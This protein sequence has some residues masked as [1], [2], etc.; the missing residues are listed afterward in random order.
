MRRRAWLS[1]TQFL[2]ANSA[3]NLIPGPNSTEVAMHVGR[4]RSGPGGLVAAGVCFI[5]PA[6]VMV[7]ALAWA[8]VEYGAL[9]QVQ[10]VAYGAKPAALA[11]IALAVVQFARTAWSSVATA[12]AG[13]AAFGLALAGVPELFTIFGMGLAGLTLRSALV[14]AVPLVELTLVFLKLGCVVFGSGYVLLA[15][16]R[17]DIVGRGWV[18]EA[19]LVDAVA[20]GQLTPGPLFT[21]ATFL[22]YLIA[23]FPGAALATV[24]IF[25]PAFV[26]VAITGRWIERMRASARAG[27]FLDFANAAAV[28][29]MLLVTWDL[30]RAAIMDLPAAIIAVVA[31]F[32]VWRLRV[33]G[34][35]VMLAAVAA[36]LLL[37]GL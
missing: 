11:M 7:C 9:P 15:W 35:F 26:L 16:L 28:G 21:T 17:A 29:V 8:Y 4:L 27:A 23:G 10:A 24:G 6:F 22:G 18:T 5:A 14:R 25:L 20:A 19:Q 13:L 12:L 1:D 34:A 32:A 2:D 3:A 30:G 31:L 37:R 36:G 33:N